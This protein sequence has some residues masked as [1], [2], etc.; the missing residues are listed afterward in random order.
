[1]TAL[2]T[3]RLLLPGFPEHCDGFDIRDLPAQPWQNGLGATREIAKGSMRLPLDTTH[4]AWDWR[5]SVADLTSPATFS[6]FEGVDRVAVLA[7]RSPVI[8]R[9]ASTTLAFEQQGDMHAFAGEQLLEAALPG[10]L[11]TQLLNVMTQRGAARATVEVTTTEWGRREIQG[12]GLF[13]VLRGT[14]AIKG[15]NIHDR[16]PL[17]VQLSP[18]QG[19]HWQ[20]GMTS[21]Q[22]TPSVPNACLAWIQIYPTTPEIQP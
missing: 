4:P 9:G 5:I 14:F 20:E 10:S 11:P 3:R 19:M 15:R 17:G 13:I 12:I 6:T 22:A 21:L 2:N 7:G 18:G 1:M 8:L 16:H